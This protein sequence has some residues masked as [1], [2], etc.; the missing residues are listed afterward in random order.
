VLF[1]IRSGLVPGSEQGQRVLLDQKGC[2]LCHSSGENIKSECSLTL[3]RR[4]KFKGPPAV[5]CSPH[6]KAQLGESHGECATE[7]R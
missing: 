5:R 3:L 2:E 6:Y 7:E 4:Q 1:C